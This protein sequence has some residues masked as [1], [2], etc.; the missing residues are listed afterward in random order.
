MKPFENEKATKVLQNFRITLEE[1]E[2]LKAE[3]DKE[4]ITVTDLIK[5]ALFEYINTK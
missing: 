4:G 1:K 5:K 2:L 3:A